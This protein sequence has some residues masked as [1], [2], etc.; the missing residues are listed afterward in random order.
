MIY[1]L[2]S[3]K[4]V[5]YCTGDDSRGSWGRG[6]GDCPV[7]RNRSCADRA[8]IGK[9]AAIYALIMTMVVVPIGVFD[10]VAMSTL[11]VLRKYP[12]RKRRVNQSSND[13]NDVSATHQWMKIRNSFCCV[14]IQNRRPLLSCAHASKTWDFEITD[15][16]S[17]SHF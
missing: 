12:A 8:V 3:Y 11:N 6:E 16:G 15:K 10:R 17:P 5:A 13:C 4:R 9:R 14:R 1:I 2:C 7:N